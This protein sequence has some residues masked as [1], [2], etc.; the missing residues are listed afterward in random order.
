MKQW[1]FKIKKLC[2]ETLKTLINEL[3]RPASSAYARD[4][5]EKSYLYYNI[6]ANINKFK[7]F[8]I[9]HN[10]VALLTRRHSEQGTRNR[11]QRV[12]RKVL[13]IYKNKMLIKRWIFYNSDETDIRLLFYR[14]FSTFWNIFG[15]FALR[16]FIHG[17][18]YL[19]DDIKS[20]V[21]WN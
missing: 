5:S 20:S 9:S 1:N 12:F 7:E 3:N 16:F 13:I 21:S 6:P 19:E 11:H 18:W 17:P 14:S 2:S 4:L 8:C 15:G 10:K